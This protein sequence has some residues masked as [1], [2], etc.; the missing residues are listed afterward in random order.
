MAGIVGIAGFEGHLR[1]G[2]KHVLYKIIKT[3]VRIM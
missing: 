3:T 2:N 1:A